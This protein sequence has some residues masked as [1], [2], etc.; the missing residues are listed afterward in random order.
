MRLRV[1][2]H[3]HID[4]ASAGGRDLA[5][6]I[7][8]GDVKVERLIHGADMLFVL[9]RLGLHFRLDLILIQDSDL[10]QITFHVIFDQCVI[11]GVVDRR[12]HF[13][14]H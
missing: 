13:L 2:R 7:D 4:I 6:C 12:I 5:K 14:V 9:L 8:T 11:S 10:I 1:H 3:D